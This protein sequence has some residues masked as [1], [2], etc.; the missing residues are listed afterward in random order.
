[1]EPINAKEI[2]LEGQL[3]YEWLVAMG[4]STGGPK[5][6]SEIIKRL[7]PKLSTAYVIVQHMPS[8]FTR[9]LA[10]RLDTLTELT[11][12]NKLRIKVEGQDVEDFKEEYSRT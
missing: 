2:Q 4:I 6:L 12:V 3:A 1:M 8:G 9:N 10:E 7:D 5:L 11:E